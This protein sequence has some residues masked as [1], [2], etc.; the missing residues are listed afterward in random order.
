MLKSKVS[1]VVPIYKVEKYLDNCIQSIVEQTYANLEIILVDDGSPD[2]CPRICDKWAK[3]D[4]R[5]KVF[6]KK[7]GGLSDARNFGL[8]NATGDYIYFVDSD[9]YINHQCIEILLNAIVETQ[10]DIAACNVLEVKENFYKQFKIDRNPKKEIL[11]NI[12]TCKK[13][14]KSGH[15]GIGIVVWNKLYKKEVFNNLRFTKG[16]IHEDEAIIYQLIYPVKKFVYVHEY[17]HYYRLSSESIMRNEFNLKRFDILKALKMRINYL[18]DKDKGLLKENQNLYLHL[19]VY[20]RYIG[21]KKM[22]FDESKIIDID[23]EI[24]NVYEQVE[25]NPR[26]YFMYNFKNIYGRIVQIKNKMR[27]L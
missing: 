9:D 25:K 27:C 20:Y 14:T 13:I 11:K 6:H 7:N 8:D 22:K 2:E 15:Q 5:I 1:I 10:S 4:N 19:L 17:L 18:K 3:K 26:N 23:N 21:K 24:K 16:I 12:E